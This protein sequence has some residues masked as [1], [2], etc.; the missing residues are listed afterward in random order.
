MNE[1]NHFEVVIRSLSIIVCAVIVVTLLFRAYRYGRTWNTKTVDAVWVLGLWSGVTL[2]AQID[3]LTGESL[4]EIRA[5]LVLLASLITL[6]M[7]FRQYA[8]QT[9]TY[10]RGMK[11]TGRKDQ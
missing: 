9:T 5:S 2:I 1:P 6:L 4:I 3:Q 7:V 8:D 11:S 10:N